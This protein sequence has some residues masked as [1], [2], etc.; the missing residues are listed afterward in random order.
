MI[1][2]KRT[3]FL[4]LEHS[5]WPSPFPIS[6]QGLLTTPLRGWYRIGSLLRDEETE[7]GSG[8]G[9]SRAGPDPADAPSLAFQSPMVL[10]PLLPAAGPPSKTVSG[11][12]GLKGPTLCIMASRGRRPGVFFLCFDSLG[13][14]V[15]LGSPLPTISG[16]LPHNGAVLGPCP[17]S[18]L[19]AE[20][21]LMLL[22]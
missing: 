4:F 14:S 22:W 8:Q 16:F 2:T 5:V 20:A 19:E 7:L 6:S 15:T 3:C 11:R 21:P 13:Y 1:N 12:W 17:S 10:G 9:I 18:L